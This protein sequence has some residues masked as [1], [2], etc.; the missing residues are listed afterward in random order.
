MCFVVLFVPPPRKGKKIQHFLFFLFVFFLSSFLSFF[1]SIFLSF[2][3][4]FLS[5]SSFFL[6]FFLSVFLSFC[7]SVFLSFFLSETMRKLSSLHLNCVLNYTLSHNYKPNAMRGQGN[8][9]LC[10]QKM[11]CL[12]IPILNKK[13]GDSVGGNRKCSLIAR[14]RGEHSSL[15][16]QQSC[17]P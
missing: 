16:S 2:S 9:G 6:S 10:H 3:S 11:G 7:L 1:L 15:V 13:H 17:P 4:F 14:Q 8:C 5:F 12:C